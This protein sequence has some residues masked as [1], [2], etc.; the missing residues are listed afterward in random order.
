[1]LLDS[2]FR[3]FY[4]ITDDGLSL[5]GNVSDVEQALEVGIK[6]VQFRE[7]RR[8]FSE[9]YSELFEIKQLCKDYGALLI[10]NDSIELALAV[11]ADGIHLGQDDS[12]ISYAREALGF[13][14][15]IGLSTGN[16][17][18]AMLAENNGADYI[19]VGHIF[20]THTKLKT[21]EP[22]GIDVLKTIKGNISI[23]VVAIGGI[24]L[25][26]IEAV[27]STGTDMICAISFSLEG[28]T[29]KENINAYLSFLG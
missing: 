13:K 28:G 24:N 3:G 17:N 11:D 14:K 22:I 9:F 6:V 27:V 29:V 7:K 12:Q 8:S 16:L 1:M 25:G 18:E 10:V 4:F 15:V 19:G 21:D 20:N 5:D 26:N 2:L 23:P